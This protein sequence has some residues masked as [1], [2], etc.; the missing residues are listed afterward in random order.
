LAKILIVDDRPINREYLVN[1][2]GY[3]GH[4]LLE[5]RDGAEALALVRAQR[6]DLVIT[7]L[8]MPTMDGYEFI[9]HLRADPSLAATPVIISTAVYHEREARALAQQGGVAHFLIKPADP[10]VVLRTVDE[11]LGLAPIPAPAPVPAEFDRE[12]LRLVSG[13]LLDKLIE[14]E[15][16]NL[17]LKA[18]IDFGQQL[19]LE[20]DPQRLLNSSCQVGREIL[21]AKYSGIGILEDDGQTF[22]HFL[23]G[24]LDAEAVAR[25][26]SPSPVK[27]VFGRVLAERCPVR[28]CDPGIE[29]QTIVGPP[30]H[31]PVRSF[32]GVPVSSPDHCYGLLY[33]TDK[34]GADEFSD[35]DERVACTLAAQVAVFYENVGAQVRALQSERLAAIGQMVTGLAHESR[36]ALQ[37]SQAC[38]EMLSLIVSDRPEA[39]NLIG[40]LQKAQDHLHNLYEDVRDYAAPIKLE[41]VTCDLR[42]V[43]RESWAHLELARRDKHAVLHEILGG[44]DLHCV[45]EPWRLN[46]VFRNLLENALAAGKA[47]VTIEIRAAAPQLNGQPA[48]SITVED[49]G[50]GIVPEQRRKA[51][52]P[53]F[54][55]KTK[56]TGLGLAISRRIVEAHGGQ[57]TIGEA[58]GP[59]AVFIITLPRGTT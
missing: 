22:R 16:A 32:L 2:L 21:C 56:G 23:I 1:V 14:L 49:D 31:P 52:D 35:D 41:K 45:G 55:T 11:A 30:R 38:L 13:T 25:V 3:A 26:G 37:R 58:Q 57:I 33:F 8:L 39:L 48:L 47:P 36:N 17:R 28:L 54:T 43:W 50:P 6:P 20:R 53:F 5:A 42:T 24:G 40:R 29:G 12:H 15:A 9:R 4:Q 44:V 7:D 27:G 59:G 19:A 46:Q 51:F 10:E 18:L 34:L